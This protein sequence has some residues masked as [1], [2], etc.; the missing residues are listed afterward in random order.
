ME[1][2]SVEDKLPE[3][4]VTVLVY[5][6][7]F[8]DTDRWNAKKGYDFRTAGVRFG[9]REKSGWFR[10]EGVNGNCQIT[11]WMPLPQEPE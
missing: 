3:K 7:M 9:R 11:H 6:L 5:D 4:E 2:I 10:S 8:V 1:W